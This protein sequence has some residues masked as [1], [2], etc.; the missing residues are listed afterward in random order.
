MGLGDLKTCVY[1]VTFY[2]EDT[3][4][5]HI[6]KYFVMDGLVICIK[7]NSYVAHIFYAWSFI[8]NASVTI[9]IKHNKYYLY[10]YTNTNV[11]CLG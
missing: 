3:D 6:L 4:N 10:L 7:L 8:H 5:T 2:K 11:C 9:L 1:Q